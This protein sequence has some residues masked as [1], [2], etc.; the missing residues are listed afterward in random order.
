V[1]ASLPESGANAFP[2]LI[3]AALALWAGA[4]AILALIDHESLVVPTKLVRPAIVVAGSL[5]ASGA[6]S[7][8]DWRYLWQGAACA[9]MAAGSFGA[10]AAVN[11]RGLGFGDARMASLVALGSGALSPPG[12]LV[13]LACSALAAGLAGRR[14]ARHVPGA[15][16]R[17]VALGPF[18]AVGGLVVVIAHAS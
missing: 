13:A 11:P 14:P 10:W 7:T 8:G 5:L 6:L 2:S 1:V 3:A 15:E 17:A 16:R 9:G 4:L 18:L 12:S